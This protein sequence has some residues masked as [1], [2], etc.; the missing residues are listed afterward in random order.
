MKG[1]LKLR[2]R[3]KELTANFQKTKKGGLKDSS[4]QGAEA[5]RSPVGLLPLSFSFG[6]KIGAH[7]ENKYE[8]GNRT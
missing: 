6:K 3:K 8:I 4:Q 1:E 5:D 7:D 2:N